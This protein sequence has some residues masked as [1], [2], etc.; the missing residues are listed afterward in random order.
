LRDGREVDRIVGGGATSHPR[1]NGSRRFYLRDRGRQ[2]HR[3]SRARG[4]G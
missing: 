2:A 1:V 3:A 4:F